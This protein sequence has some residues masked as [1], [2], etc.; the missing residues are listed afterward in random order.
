MIKNAI[1]NTIGKHNIRTEDIGGQATT[2]EFM[3]CVI[4]EIQQL[5][6]ETGLFLAA[7]NIV[8]SFLY[9]YCAIKQELSLFKIE[10]KGIRMKKY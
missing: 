10:V 7:F 9:I 1:V 2:T 8:N 5:T 3:K 6:P 4:D